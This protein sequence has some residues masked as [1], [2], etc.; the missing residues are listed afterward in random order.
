MRIDEFVLKENM[1][2]KIVRD[3]TICHPALFK[4][5]YIQILLEEPETGDLFRSKIL[6]G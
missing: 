3:V 5:G 4:T 6:L 2:G 1:C